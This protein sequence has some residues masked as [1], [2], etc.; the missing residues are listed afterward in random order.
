[1][2]REKLVLGYQGTLV[3]L[4]LPRNGSA[5]GY[6]EMGQ[7]FS[8]KILWS[9]FSYHEL[10]GHKKSELNT[11][12]LVLRCVIFYSVFT[13]LIG[14]SAY[15]PLCIECSFNIVDKTSNIQNSTCL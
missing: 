8:N 6:P 15:T 1:M 7:P 13:P 3:S 2:S 9:A 11:V 12:R 14:Q 5:L 10:G 4:R